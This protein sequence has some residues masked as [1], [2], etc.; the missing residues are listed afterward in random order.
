MPGFSL[1][2]LLLPRPGEA[3]APSAGDILSLLE[4]GADAPGWKWSSTAP[5]PSSAL[6][7]SD[8]SAGGLD[9]K[10]GSHPKISA[11]D[12]Q[13][14]V[15]SITKACRALIA[16]EPEITHMDN[17]AGDGDCGLTLKAGAEGQN[18]YLFRML[19]CLTT[20]CFRCS[21]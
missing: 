20:L 7:V 13:A 5:P 6:Q 2:L 8:S 14:F 12:S 21:E 4:E 17:I 18:F 9:L 10:A 15:D 16:A 11:P 19:L 1:T 3:H